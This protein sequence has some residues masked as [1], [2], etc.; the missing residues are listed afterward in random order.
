MLPSKMRHHPPI[1]AGV[2]P[3][4]AGCVPPQAAMPHGRKPSPTL[5]LGARE[6]TGGSDFQAARA[7]LREREIC[8][9]PLRKLQAKQASWRESEPHCFQS[10]HMSHI[11]SRAAVGPRR[12]K[13][14]S[15]VRQLPQISTSSKLQPP[16]PLR[17]FTPPAHV[18]LPTRVGACMCGSQ[19][20]PKA[21]ARGGHFAAGVFVWRLQFLLWDLI[22][23][24]RAHSCA[25]SR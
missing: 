1:P 11:K 8:F 10:E 23:F 16:Q 21:Q 4:A 7:D 25:Q 13:G 18:P 24:P 9:H 2:P 19:L 5:S 22:S 17:C 6:T 3:R 14:D 20:W 15:K 12:L